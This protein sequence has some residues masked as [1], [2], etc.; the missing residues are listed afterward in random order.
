MTDST[1]PAQTPTPALRSVSLGST[2]RAAD[3]GF[4]TLADVS[5][6]ATDLG[7]DYRI[8]GGHMVTLFVAAYGV[9]DQVPTRETVD[10]DFAALPEVIADPRL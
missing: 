7:V 9:S 10:A 5:V 3:A 6:I 8:V 2:S 1:P 4:L